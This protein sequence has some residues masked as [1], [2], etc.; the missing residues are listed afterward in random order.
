MKT[1]VFSTKPFERAYL[2][3]ALGSEHPLSFIEANLT[4]ETA[5]L[6]HGSEAVAIFST[7]DAS[8]P[9]LDVLHAQG[10]RFMTIRATGHDQVDLEHAQRLGL[11]VANVPEYS[12]YAIAEHAVALMLALNRRLIQ[13]DRQLRAYDFRL[14]E[15]IGFDLHGKTV[16]IIGLG[17]IG[18]I[19][20]GILKGFGCRLLGYDPLPNQE[21]AQRHG[22]TYTTLEQLCAE[23]D[24]ITLHAPMVPHAPYL[25]NAALLAQMKPGVMLI[26]TSRGAEL[27]TEAALAALDSGQLGYLGL[28]VYE[29][30]QAL[31]FQDHSQRPPTDAVFARLLTYPNVLITGHQAFLTQEALRNIAATTHQNLDAWASGQSLA[32]E[33][34]H[35]PVRQ[36][37]QPV[38]PH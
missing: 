33:L 35:A 26:N 2:S 4:V 16:G 31:F 12:P 21:L 29:R 27:D 25:I 6:A 7:D 17:H 9:V 11:H 14:D 36:A 18:G 20:A 1:T 24:I 37:A 28:D 15:L 10:V 3:D 8:A 38:L 22:L 34:T 30:E 19:V 13:A 32:T 5:A 23:A